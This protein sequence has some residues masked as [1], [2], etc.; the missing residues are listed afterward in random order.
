MA[1]GY[2]TTGI[3]SQASHGNLAMHKWLYNLTLPGIL[4]YKVNC[5]I[6]ID[7]YIII[8]PGILGYIANYYIATLSDYTTMTKQKPF[9][10]REMITCLLY[11]SDAADE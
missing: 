10:L 3:Y 7:V 5:Y 4:G 2:K 8:L 6:A 11:T 1:P 9:I